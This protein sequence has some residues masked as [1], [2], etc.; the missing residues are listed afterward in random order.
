MRIPAAGLSDEDLQVIESEIRRLERSLQTFLDFARPPGWSA[1]QQDLVALIEQTLSLIR[2]RA[3]KQHVTIAWQRP[4]SPVRARSGWRAVAAGAGQPA[5]QRPRCL[6]P[7]RHH[8]R[9]V[10]GPGG[11]NVEVSVRGHRGRASP[12]ELMPRLFEPFAS[13][14]DTGLG[15]GLVGLPPHR[16][17]PRRHAAGAQSSRGRCRVHVRPSHRGED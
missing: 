3:E 2:G 7:G 10:C 4:A 17:G 14:K 16:R 5:A 15:M 11:S 1:S 9:R 12:P 13:G 8:R 6:A